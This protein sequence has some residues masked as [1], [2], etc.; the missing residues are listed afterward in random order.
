MLVMVHFDL[1]L[2][3]GHGY[4]LPRWPSGNEL[5]SRTFTLDLLSG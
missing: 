1:L 4:T 2:V 5:A 3:T